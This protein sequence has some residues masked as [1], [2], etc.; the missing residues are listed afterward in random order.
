MWPER[1]VEGE[2]YARPRWA[3]Q[4]WLLTLLASV[5]LGLWGGQTTLVAGVGGWRDQQAFPE[6][7]AGP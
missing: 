3:L 2:A 7:R 1:W 4:P 6:G 5:S